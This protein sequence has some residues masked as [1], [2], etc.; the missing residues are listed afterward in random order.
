MKM[1]MKKSEGKIAQLIVT[2]QEPASVQLQTGFT[3]KKFT[4]VYSLFFTESSITAAPFDFR[5]LAS[6]FRRFSA[7]HIQFQASACLSC[8]QHASRA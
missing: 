2:N 3:T 7:E 4:L 5:R 8:Y 1:N 6:I